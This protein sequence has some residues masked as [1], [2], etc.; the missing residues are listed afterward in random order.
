MK[1]KLGPPY[2]TII[3]PSGVEEKVFYLSFIDFKERS[4]TF[5]PLY[6]N[7]NPMEAQHTAAHEG[8]HRAITRG[9]HEIGLSD[10]Q[11]RKLSSP[12]YLG[13]YSF[14]NIALEDPRVDTW[15]AARF[16]GLRELNKMFY[17]KQFKKGGQFMVTEVDLIMRRLGYYPRY[18]EAASELVRYWHEGRYR[19]G[20]RQEIQEFL[21][22]VQEYV[23]EYIKT[24]PSPEGD[25]QESE[26]IEKAQEC[27]E[28]Y[29]NYIWPYVKKLVEMDLRTE[30]KRQMVQDYRQKQRELEQKRN[31]MK[32]AQ[33]RGDFQRQ[34]ELQQ[35]I[36]RL[37]EELKPFDELPEDVRRELEEQID[38]AIRE[39]A[40]KLNKEIEEIERQIKEAR[41]RQEELEREIRELEEEVETARGKEKE[42]LEK[43]IRQKVAEKAAQEMKQK[44]AERNLETIRG[45]LDD[46]QSENM[47]PYP[48]DKLSERTKQELEKLFKRLSA[49]KQ[50]EL[51]A[52]AR[53]Q[54]EDLEDQINE[55][56]KAGGELNTDKPERHK[57]RRGIK[58]GR[59]ITGPETTEIERKL[60]IIV[61]ERMTPYE[62]MRAQVAGLIDDL[63]YRLRRIL[64]PEEYGREEAGYPSG[65]LLD[66]S[67][68]MQAEVDPREKLKLWLRETSPGYYDYRF[69][70]IIDV[71]NSMSGKKIE[72]TLKGAIV[73]GEVINRLEDLDPDVIKIHQEII[74]FHT[75]IFP[76]KEFDQRFTREVE[77]K[78][79]ILPQKT[80]DNDAGT[81]LYSPILYALD[82][83]KDNLGKTANFILVFSDGLPN[84][85]IRDMLKEL[86]K[87]TKEERE[88]L[89]IKIGLI[90]LG[91]S[92]DE[93]DLRLLLREYDYDFGLVMPAVNPQNDKSFSERLA[94]LLEDI[95]TNPEKY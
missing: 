51:K 17:D 44:Q 28:I 56:T 34:Q 13:F 33:E 60:K 29:H 15:S 31:E 10:E 83:L 74:A 11:I 19:E 2:L 55:A 25:L 46:I 69:V 40:E 94:D 80:Q 77:D 79:S 7:E 75:R 18:A 53:R 24:F 39:T 3:N 8:A 5:N 50:K 48:E 89:K 91:E 63:Y 62:E 36:E 70:I 4:I 86:L 76:I 73:V 78:L 1:V 95:I 93:G 92:N 88:Q 85:N 27:F 16:P 37:E 42:N 14:Y 87:T 21:K 35:E 12:E 82:S 32:K 72:E 20:L 43:Q 81:N 67:R 64:K 61:Q 57:E 6:V 45:S 59:E 68:A 65:Q 49:Q 22:R 30:E 23:T 38:E 58:A 26:V 52:K 41:Q 71:S 47:I 66:I 90:W 54:L 84:E 9:Y